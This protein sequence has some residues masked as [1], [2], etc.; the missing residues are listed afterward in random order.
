M[1]ILYKIENNNPV[2]ILLFFSDSL[3]DI[4]NRTFTFLSFTPQNLTINE[5]QILSEMVS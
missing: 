1:Q 4:A 5:I 3:Y 2:N